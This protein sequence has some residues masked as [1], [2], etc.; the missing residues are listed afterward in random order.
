[1]WA[2]SGQ[3]LFFRNGEALLA[4]PVATDPSFTVGNSE[5]IFEGQYFEGPFGGRAYDISS[6]GERFLMIKRI[7]NTS[8]TPRITVVQNWFEELERLAPLPE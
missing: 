6:D 8:A 2:R 7:E 5:V 3:D 1:L 4:V